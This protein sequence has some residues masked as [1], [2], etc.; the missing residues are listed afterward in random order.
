[1]GKEEGIVRGDLGEFDLPA[2][3]ASEADP[4]D[5]FVGQGLDTTLPE[6]PLAVG[7]LGKD[8]GPAGIVQVGLPEPLLPRRAAIVVGIGGRSEMRLDVVGHGIT[9]FVAEHADDVILRVSP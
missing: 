4:L 8:A 9:D 3:Q 1:M 5:D 2:P 6:R 7:I